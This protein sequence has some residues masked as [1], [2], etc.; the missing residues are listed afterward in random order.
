MIS[1][2][3]IPNDQLVH[4]EK[5]EQSIKL[6]CNRVTESLSKKS[7]LPYIPNIYPVPMMIV[8]ISTAHARMVRVLFY[9]L[10]YP[11]KNNFERFAIY[12]TLALIERLPN[13]LAGVI[14]HEIAHIIAL[15]GRVS[16][17][18]SDLYSVLGNK[19]DNIRLREKKAEMVYK[20]FNEPI[21][22]E[23][24]RWD[25]TRM[26]KDIEDIVSNDVQLV[27]QQSFDRIVFAEKMRHFHDFI[28]SMLDESE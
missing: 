18:K 8:R 15:E 11:D 17:S 2:E 5:I 27:S 24:N 16:I 14:G 12:P 21:R 26:R 25:R 13:H 20:Y 3:Y 7:S 9:S 28:K 23:I 22:S 19:E 1:A 4:F 6:A 10:V